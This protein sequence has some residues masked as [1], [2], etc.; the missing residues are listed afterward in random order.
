[1]SWVHAFKTNKVGKFVEEMTMVYRVATEKKIHILHS[2]KIHLLELIAQQSDNWDGECLQHDIE[3]D[4]VASQ[5]ALSLITPGL[6]DQHKSRIR[7]A[8]WRT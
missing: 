5:E 3:Q 7:G 2:K 6:F 1:V 4:F 8:D